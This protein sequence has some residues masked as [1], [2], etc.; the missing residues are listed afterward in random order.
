MITKE[1]LYDL[2]PAIYRKKDQELGNP[3][4]SLFD[5]ISKQANIIE[6]DI[7]E[8]YDNW[9][10]E[11]CKKWVIPYIG[12][13]LGV[14]NIDASTVNLSQRALVANQIAHMRRKG[15]IH[16]LEQLARDI[17]G[18]DSRAVE[19]FQFLPV[20]QNL[21]NLNLKNK[22]V[23]LRQTNEL[24]LIGSPFDTMCHT[25]D[26][27]TIQD[28]NGWYNIQNLG[29]FFWRLQTFPVVD[30]TAFDHKDGKFSFD[31]LGNDIELYNNPITEQSISSIAKEKNLP[32]SIR[33]KAL[34][35]N[36]YDYYGDDMSIVIEVN[37]TNVD[38]DRIIVSNLIDWENRPRAD[39]IAVDPELGRILFPKNE[40]P[41]KVRVSYYYAFSGNV[42]S[43]PYERDDSILSEK[44]NSDKIQRYYVIKNEKIR[45]VHTSISLDDTDEDLKIFPS[46]SGA[47]NDWQSNT[48]N[49][50][51]T[52]IFEIMDSEIYDEPI[53]KLEMKSGMSLEIRSKMGQRPVLK[54]DNPLTVKS[55]KQNSNANHE[56]ILVLDGLLIDSSHEL[57]ESE[58]LIHIE[59][60]DLRFL[61][62][63]Q[64]TL[65]PNPKNQKSID[66]PS[67]N[68]RLTVEIKNSI[69]GTI[70]LGTS[71]ATI[72]LV[73]SIA[74]GQKSNG[75]T[76]SISC[77]DLS[78]ENCTIIGN[79]RTSILNIAKN[80]IFTDSLHVKR[81]QQGTVKF[82][83]LKSN[84]KA[85]KCYKCIMK[86][87]GKIISTQSISP[88]T[89]LP[90]F[91]SLRYGDPGYAQ[92][93]IHNT[94]KEILE[95]SDNL[96]E[97]GVFNYLNQTSRI[98]NFKSS[99]A[100]Y[101]RF[102]KETAMLYVT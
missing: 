84:S 11:T 98:N 48:D 72:K 92:L 14:Q 59:N 91:I 81:R 19:F 86:S 63:R 100:N 38:S 62:I 37:G 10:I 56:S 32:G 36:F 16:S 99:L 77:Y 34:K 83:Y 1:T 64:C 33:R 66:L 30:S 18:W 60:G 65:V 49:S 46:L 41:K 28:K 87:S 17:T 73:N 79:V 22:T 39:M 52:A 25:L 43:N 31:P 2:L 7:G 85:P 70:N 51:S 76:D 13:L 53:P 55:S 50:H 5:V 57:K 69:I 88:N 44:F 97:I 21:N 20:T 93:D 96:Q 61:H 42:G 12:D 9:F 82:C 58:S 29:L 8:V 40:I 71:D 95:G 67:G 4:E 80:S 6:S 47:I 35:N 26:T 27:K 75:S 45:D 3:L 78:V 23:D 101:L 15:T 102:G 90:N 54:L 68:E 89:D 94:P 74:D 24:E